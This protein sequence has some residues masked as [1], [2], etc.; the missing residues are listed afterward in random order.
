MAFLTF[1]L[2]FTV[3]SG[4]IIGSIEAD[5]VK[6]VEV[7]TQALDFDNLNSILNA[8]KEYGPTK[9]PADQKAASQY[10]CTTVLSEEEVGD[11]SWLRNGFPDNFRTNDRRIRVQ[12]NEESNKHHGEK[13]I[14]E[15]YLGGL[16][17]EMQRDSKANKLNIYPVVIM[18][19]YYIPCS[20]INHVCAKR[21]ADDKKSRETKYSLVLGY[22]D[23]YIYQMRHKNPKELTIKNIQD[24]FKTL[25][26]GTIDVYYMIRDF[27]NQLSSIVLQDSMSDLIQTNLYNCLIKQP[28]AY[29]C[30]ANLD[31]S[32]PEAVD[33]VSKVVTFSINSMI[34]HCREFIS[35]TLFLAKKSRPCFDKWMGVNIGPDCQKCASGHFGREDL[36][37]FTNQCLNQA[38]EVSK[39]VGAPVVPNNLVHP[40]WEN[41]PNFWNVTPADFQ[42]NNPLYC[43]NLTLRPDS[44]CTKTEGVVF[45]EPDRKKEKLEP[46]P[47]LA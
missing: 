21:L 30:S 1:V 12:Y 5:K 25:R 17:A 45:V 35:S 27:S 4:N 23:Y 10:T 26:D 39:Y 16:I 20:M 29:C 7:N 40:S 22:S 18:Y 47:F 36:L 24:S 37:F 13:I 11:I 33:D 42:M 46:Q 2:A 3:L 32:G 14:L 6:N 8:L 44:F 9:K 43:Y 38:W 41:A 34:Y 31:K 28:L 19:S 15:K